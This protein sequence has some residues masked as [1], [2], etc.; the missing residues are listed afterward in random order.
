MVQFIRHEAGDDERA[1]DESGL[2]YIGDASVDERAGI[3]DYL[4]S[5]RH[6]AASDAFTSDA[7][8]ALGDMQ[9]KYLEDLPALEY[10]DGGEYYAQDHSYNDRA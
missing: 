5:A 8:N 7:S 9:P 1:R 4:I 3:D 10:R 6:K 2:Y